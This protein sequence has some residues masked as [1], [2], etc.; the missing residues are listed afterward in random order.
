MAKID[1][2]IN[3]DSQIYEKQQQTR[4]I[5]YKELNRLKE[6]LKLEV[7]SRK[8][9]DEEIAVALEKYQELISKEVETKRQDIKGSRQFSLD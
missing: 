2:V 4:T 5:L 9:A 7:D 3:Q 1:H 8:H 6:Q